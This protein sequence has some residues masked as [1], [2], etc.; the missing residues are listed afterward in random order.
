MFAASLRER[1][2]FAPPW[3][4]ANPGSDDVPMVSG[5]GCFYP[6]WWRLPEERAVEIRA[7]KYET[8]PVPIQVVYP[9]A[10]LMSNKMRLFVDE[11]VG[12]LRRAK[13]D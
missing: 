6:I 10:R 11:C 3:R 2:V 8:E 12:K 5:L 13:F 7:G 4:S 9:Q 1:T